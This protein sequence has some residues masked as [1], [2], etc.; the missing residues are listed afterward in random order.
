[1]G[2]AWAGAIAFFIT[3]INRLYFAT[4]LLPSISKTILRTL[5]CSVVA[6]TAGIAL[7]AVAVFRMESVGARL[8]VGGPMIAIGVT[9]V[10]LILSPHLRNEL[11]QLFVSVRARRR[12]M[13]FEPSS[14]VELGRWMA[15]LPC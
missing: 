13:G 1:M 3:M 15:A 7:G 12:G 14:G 6:T 9:G 8:L 5:F 4:A 2:A 11:S 10:M